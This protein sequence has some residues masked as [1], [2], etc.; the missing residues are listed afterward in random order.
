MKNAI[1]I[2]ALMFACSSS[3]SPTPSPDAAVNPDLRACPAT[4]MADAYGLPV[5]EL[6]DNGCAQGF[7]SMKPCAYATSDGTLKS[8]NHRRVVGG[9]L[10]PACCVKEGNALVTKVC[11]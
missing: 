6:C 11:Q 2:T 5:A 3:S 10:V 9:V 1:L 4:A 8:C 7:Q